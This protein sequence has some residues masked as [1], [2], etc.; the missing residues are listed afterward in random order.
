MRHVCART[1]IPLPKCSTRARAGSSWSAS[2]A[3]TCSPRCT[4]RREASPRRRAPARGASYAPRHDHRTR[5]DARG[6]RARRRPRGSPRPPPA[7]RH[8]HTGRSR[9][10]RLGRT[11][12]A[13]IPRATSRTP[14]RCSLPESRPV[15]GSTAR[16]YPSRA[17]CS[18]APSS[19]RPIVKR[20]SARCR[21]WSSGGSRIGTTPMPNV[22]AFGDCRGERRLRPRDLEQPAHRV[23]VER[24]AHHHDE[25]GRPRVEV[26][27]PVVDLVG[28]IADGALDLAR[29][30]GRAWRTTRRAPRSCA[31]KFS[32]GPN[33]FHPS[34]YSATSRSVTF[35][36]LPPMRIGRSPDGRRGRAGRAAP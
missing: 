7:Q 14:G 17:V 32:G 16:W 6:A 11:R 22:S 5:L 31:A 15:D 8:E 9:R 27:L 35:S 28:L 3:P 10:H 12:G 24:V 4:R 23:E 26:R 29:G 2:T 21:R 1:G 19:A 36:P 30:R 34:A 20:R 33:V 25:V 18:C 13:A